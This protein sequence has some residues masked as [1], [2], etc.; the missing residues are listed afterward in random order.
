MV[1]PKESTPDKRK[2]LRELY[3]IYDLEKKVSKVYNIKKFYYRHNRVISFTI[4]F[5]IIISAMFS[6]IIIIF[7]RFE[8]LIDIRVDFSLFLSIFASIVSIVTFFI[9]LIK[10]MDYPVSEFKIRKSLEKEDYYE[11]DFSITNSGHGKLKLDFAAYFIEQFEASSKLDSFLYC[12]TED[13]S[14][15]LGE[16]L[17]RIKHKVIKVYSLSAITKGYNVFFPHNY[18]HIESRLHKL[19]KNKIYMITFFYQTSH[20]IFYY[21]LKHIIT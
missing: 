15:Y 18:T 17:N 8:I 5:F 11:F 2:I 9:N 1:L 6:V 4:L 13:I 3:D 14:Q 10:I 19:E 20:K 21:V 12:D 7:Y 16:L